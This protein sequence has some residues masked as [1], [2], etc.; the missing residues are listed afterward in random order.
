M[1]KV[2]VLRRTRIATAAAANAA[3]IARG[4]VSAGCLKE[5]MGGVPAGHGEAF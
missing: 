5:R 4:I 1:S 3:G 2:R